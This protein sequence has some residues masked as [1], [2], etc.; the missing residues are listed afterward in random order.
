MY[1]N[2]EIIKFLDIMYKSDCKSG[3]WYTR[4]FSPKQITNA[5]REYIKN[6]KDKIK[7]EEFYD[8]FT[9]QTSICFGTMERFFSIVFEI[10]K[11]IYMNELF[12]CY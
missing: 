11:D 8:T 4:K 5:I 3:L 2:D 9:N 7:F 10:K 6:S 1:N 12:I